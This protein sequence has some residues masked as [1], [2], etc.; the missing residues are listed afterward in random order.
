LREAGQICLLAAVS[1]PD[2]H[3]VIPRLEAGKDTRQLSEIAVAFLRW[4]GLEP[5]IYQDEESA[6][7]NVGR[8]LLRNRYPLLLTQLD[9]AG[10]KTSE[11]FVG[12]GEEA[13]ECG[14][15]S[16]LAVKPL[17]VKEDELSSFLKEI[18]LLVSDPYAAAD[19]S[20]IV[21]LVSQ[22]IPQFKHLASPQHLD[23]RM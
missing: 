6:R 11:I 3:I 9:T 18:E 22:V 7:A 1:G 16:L 23:Q 21:A 12:D 19:K 8:E 10:E 5:E 14:M 4:R 20:L 15:S 2:R 17:P 13:I